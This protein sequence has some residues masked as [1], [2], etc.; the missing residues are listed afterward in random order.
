MRMTFSYTSFVLFFASL[1]V[2]ITELAL[3]SILCAHKRFVTRGFR[4][5]KYITREI[6][7]SCRYLN[8][9]LNMLIVDTL[10]SP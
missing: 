10:K 4:L 8:V 5:Y 3:G 6:S 2:A 9:C 1:C 7:A